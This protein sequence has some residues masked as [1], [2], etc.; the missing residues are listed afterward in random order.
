MGDLRWLFLVAHLAALVIGLGPAV[1]IE[2]CGFLWMLGRGS[3]GNVRKTERRLSLL[4]W[5][6]FSGMLLSGMF[7]APNLAE[8]MTALKLVG[9]LLI[10]LNAVNSRSL[11]RQLMPLRKKLAF[12]VAPRRL[13][14]WCLTNGTI[15]QLLWWTA[16]LIGALNTAGRGS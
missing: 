2:Y 8:P 16:V 13:Q 6:G 12:R 14:L 11:M 10:G 9:V 7:L 3:L 4:S 1:M 5:L 15:S